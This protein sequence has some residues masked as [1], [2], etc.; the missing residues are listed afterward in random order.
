VFSYIFSTGQS[1]RFLALSFRMDHYIEGK[2]V[3]QISDVL[4][5]K[6]SSKH[7]TVPD[8]DRFRT[9]LLSFQIDGIFLMLSTAYMESTFALNVVQKLDHCLTNF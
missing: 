5:S 1:F 9:Q 4:W 6:L 2:I 8:H 3:D 7:L